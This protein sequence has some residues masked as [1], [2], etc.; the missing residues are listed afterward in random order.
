MRTWNDGLVW[1]AW[2]IHTGRW[3][4]VAVLV[5]QPRHRGLLR[6]EGHHSDGRGAVKPGRRGVRGTV[7]DLW[8]GTN[9]VCDTGRAIRG[10]N[11]PHDQLSAAAEAGEQP[12]RVATL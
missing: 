8:M 9:V 7:N 1:D 3:P 2:G 4:A 5:A 12:R 6:G 10:L 11:T